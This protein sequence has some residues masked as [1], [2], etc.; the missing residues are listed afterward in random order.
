MHLQTKASLLTLL[1]VLFWSTS[2][3]AFKLALRLVTPYTLLLYSVFV[4]VLVLFTLLFVQ[5]RLGVITGI[6]RRDLIRAAALGMVNPLLYYMVLFKA[7]AFLPG[8]IAMS[9]N[10]AWPL[11]LTLLSVP[12][13]RQRLRPVQ[14]A[15]VAVSFAGAVIIAT[16]GSFS[17]FEEISGLGVIFAAGSAIIWALFWLVNARD[18]VE[19][20]CKLFI[21]FS[22]GLF[23]AL[24][25]SPFFGGIP[26]P[27][28]AAFGPLIYIGFFEMS[29]TFVLWLTALQLTSSAARI[30]NLVY[31]VPFL[32]LVFLR[33]VVGETIHPAT[34]IGLGLI[35]G[36]ILFQEV[37]S[38]CSAAAS[39]GEE[40]N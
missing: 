9:L 7:Y 25:L 32:S 36:S 23:F 8:Q 24:I 14:L 16:R 11:V 39:S 13:L 15:A 40:V 5:G 6:P 22:A 31:M 19:P 28:L 29:F 18:Q 12:L 3:S 38:S 21:G 10:Y 20:T 1:V 4:A 37:N 35:V 26:L 17:G 30:G 2:A 27:P 34:F 33:L